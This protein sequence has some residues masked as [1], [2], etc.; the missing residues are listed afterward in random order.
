MPFRV[1]PA[2]SPSASIRA[3]VSEHYGVKN[4]PML[5]V[6][7]EDEIATYESEHSEVS[8]NIWAW[9]D[10]DLRL[11]RTWARADKCVDLVVWCDETKTY[12]MVQDVCFVDAF[13]SAEEWRKAVY[14]L[15]RTSSEVWVVE[16][17]ETPEPS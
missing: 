1:A 16:H 5:V 3:L 6:R 13:P 10:H 4:M 2:L 15:I 7:K 8:P 9:V 14:T 17:L 11:V 12:R